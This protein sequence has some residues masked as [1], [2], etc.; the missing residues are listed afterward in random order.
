MVCQGS[1]AVSPAALRLKTRVAVLASINDAARQ[2]RVQ[3]SRVSKS[4]DKNPS[5]VI[6][7]L[8]AFHLPLHH[9]Q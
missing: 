7:R 5:L 2:P 1:V 3:H 4:Y 8:L 9:Q 6:D